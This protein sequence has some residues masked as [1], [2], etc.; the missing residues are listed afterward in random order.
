[1]EPERNTPPIPTLADAIRHIKRVTPAGSRWDGFD[2]SDD[3]NNA[4]QMDVI[5]ASIMNGVADGE[6][7]RKAVLDHAIDRCLELETKLAEATEERYA[8]RAD[9]FKYGIEMAAATVEAIRIE[10]TKDS[11]GVTAPDYFD[12]GTSAAYEAIRALAQKGE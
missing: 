4:D 8:A 10:D 1:M 11:H 12:E 3:P 6:L 9:G 7:V 5:C 2:F